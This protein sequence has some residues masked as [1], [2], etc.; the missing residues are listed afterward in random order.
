MDSTTKYHGSI[1]SNAFSKSWGKVF[2]WQ[3]QLKDQKWWLTKLK[4]CKKLMNSLTLERGKINL[5]FINGIFITFAF[6]YLQI[7]KLFLLLYI[8]MG[9]CILH[10][11]MWT[12][13]DICCLLCRISS[14]YKIIMTCSYLRLTLRPRVCRAVVLKSIF[15]SVVVLLYVSDSWNWFK[16]LPGSWWPPGLPSPQTGTSVS[17][18][19]D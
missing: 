12:K 19:I 8:D 13:G 10:D 3:W 4:G 6:L 5:S 9:C 7:Y 17:K 18:L 1:C 16:V 11:P 14:C 2:S 15:E